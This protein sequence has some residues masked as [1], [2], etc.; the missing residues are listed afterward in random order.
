MEPV[1]KKG[2]GHF[3]Q[4]MPLLGHPEPEIDVLGLDEL[5]PVAPHG[6]DGLTVHQGRGVDEK[7]GLAP[8]CHLLELRSCERP[9][10]VHEPDDPSC[11]VDEIPQGAH[12]AHI[13][14]LPDE[15]DL[16]LEFVRQEEVVCIEPG[17]PFAP[18]FLEARDSPRLRRPDWPGTGCG[19][20]HRAGRNDP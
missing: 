2:L 6:K 3:Q 4:Q 18:G 13:G 10:G 1:E 9:V 15:C 11:T 7:D 14:M 5:F 8:P 20:G 12:D 19:C 16:P 17:N